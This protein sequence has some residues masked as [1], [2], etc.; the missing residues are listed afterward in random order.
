[1]SKPIFIGVAGNI[2]AGKTTLTEKLSDAIQ[3]QPV[4]ESVVDNPYL[5]DFYGNMNRWSFNLQVYFLYH[6]FQ[7]QV[8][9]LKSN[10]NFIQDRT[11]YEDKE[12]FA[13]NLFNIDSMDK[14]DW[15][16]YKQ[17]YL[18]M[19]GFIKKPDLIIYLKTSTDVLMSRIKKRKRNFEKE[20]SPEYI[21]RLNVYYDKW[22][23]SLSRDEV[24]IFNTDNFNIF[25][26]HVVFEELVELIEKR[27]K[28]VK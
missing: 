27:L 7:S 16:T 15:E 14:R 4:Y 8:D 28:L 24:L 12:I 1:M 10:K 19:L 22:I 21:Y 26:D 2:G 9:L 23:D 25:K 6:R 17:L 3:F 5:Q 18:S 13:R 11:I 20:I